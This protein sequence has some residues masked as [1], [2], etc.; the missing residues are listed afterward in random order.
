[1][2]ARKSTD[3]FRKL[4]GEL[5]KRHVYSEPIY[6]YAVLHNAPGALATWLRQ[7]GDFLGECGP[8]LDAKLVRIDP[9]ERR[10]YEHLEYSPLVNQRAHRVG[11]EQRI[12]NPVFRAQ[13]QALLGGLAHKPALDAMDEMSVVY[14]LFLQDRVEEALA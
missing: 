7:R 10:A 9:I 14:Y 8:Y 13:Y 5:E 12:P 3:F 4:I 6:R 11:A 1:W 2:R